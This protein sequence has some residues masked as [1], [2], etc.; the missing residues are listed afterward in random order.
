[1]LEVKSEKSEKL[2]EKMKEKTYPCSTAVAANLVTGEIVDEKLTSTFEDMDDDTLQMLETK[3]KMEREMATK[4]EEGKGN[5]KQKQKTLSVW[6]TNMEALQDENKM[7]ENEEKETHDED[8]KEYTSSDTA[9]TLPVPIAV[10]AIMLEQIR[11]QLSIFPYGNRGP[12]L[13]IMK[14]EL[15]EELRKRRHETSPDTDQ[16]LPHGAKKI[17]S[18]TDS[19]NFYLK[20]TNVNRE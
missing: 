5:K 16:T 13:H 12:Q 15:E 18:P 20:I 11:R 2:E 19:V 3:R 1:M 6:I 17:T 14:A 8:K 7:K 10:K 9:E 4:K